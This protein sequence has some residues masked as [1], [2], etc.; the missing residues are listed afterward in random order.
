[1][2]PDGSNVRRPHLA[3]W[4]GACLPVCCFAP[5]GRGCCS[6]WNDTITRYG[7]EMG[8]WATT[9]R[10]LSIR[11]PVVCCC[12]GG[13]KPLGSGIV[14]RGCTD[15]LE[16]VLVWSGCCVCVDSNLCSVQSSTAQL[17]ACLPVAACI[18]MPPTRLPAVQPQTAPGVCRCA[19]RCLCGCVACIS[20]SHLCCCR[21][22]ICLWALRPLAHCTA[23]MLLPLAAWPR[24]QH[25]CMAM[26]G[27]LHAAAAS[28]QTYSCFKARKVLHGGMRWQ[29]QLPTQ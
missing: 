3:C 11:Q 22:S 7:P 8:V 4:A 23:C 12:W 14:P 10:W 16:K 9:H 27:H 28:N 21:G 18:A 24:R 15:R 26:T 19:I 29:Q 1:M 13:E 5:S 25:H 17:G 2:G 6:P 20:C